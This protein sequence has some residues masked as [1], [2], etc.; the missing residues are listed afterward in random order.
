MFTPELSRESFG[1]V[2]CVA[3]TLLHIILH[4]AV[5]LTYFLC[6]RSPSLSILSV[7]SPWGLTGDLSLHFVLPSFDFNVNVTIQQDG[8]EGRAATD[9]WKLKKK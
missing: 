7:K 3:S 1:G 9:A 2:F 6:D 8:A 5:A 4:S